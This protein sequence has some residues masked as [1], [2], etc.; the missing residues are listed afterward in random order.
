MSTIPIITLNLNTDV[1]PTNRAEC[2]T[3]IITMVKSD[4]ADTKHL[5]YSCG[6][7]VLEVFATAM[8]KQGYVTFSKTVFSAPAPWKLWNPSVALTRYAANH[9]THAN[10]LRTVIQKSGTSTAPPA[11]VLLPFPKPPPTAT[12]GLSA[13]IAPTSLFLGGNAGTCLLVSQ[14]RVCR[15]VAGSRKILRPVFRSP[16]ILRPV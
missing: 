14:D 12:A 6:D 4:G 7:L 10:E 3:G 13:K 9:P 5:W 11:F 2:T 15:S 1:P 8:Q 16:K